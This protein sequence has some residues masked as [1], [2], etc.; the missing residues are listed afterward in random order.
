M[1]NPEVVT[2]FGN[3]D[4][5]AAPLNI[6]QLVALLNTLITSQI[7]GSYIPY[8]IQHGEPG[9]NDRDKAW[10][11]VDTQ[12]RPVETRIWWENGSAWRRVYNGMIGEVRMYNGNPG[13]DFDSDGLGNIGGNY[14]GWHLCNGKDG[15]PDLSDNFP[16]AAHMNNADGHTGYCLL[17]TSP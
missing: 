17:Y 16:I 14:D 5:D 3:P 9:V 1:A 13:T 4:P 10:I 15:T 8:V 7:Q 2:Q 11:Y 6:T 12:G